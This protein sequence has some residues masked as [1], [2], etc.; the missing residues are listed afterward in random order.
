M[1]KI[2]KKRIRIFSSYWRCF[3]AWCCFRRKKKYQ[4]CNHLAELPKHLQKNRN[5]YL[6]PCSWR[7][8]FA[9]LSWFQHLSLY[10]IYFHWVHMSE[11]ATDNNVTQKLSPEH[12]FEL[13][14]LERWS[15]NRGSEPTFVQYIAWSCRYRSG[16]VYLF[17]IA[18]FF[19]IVH[20][21]TFLSLSHASNHNFFTA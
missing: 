20:M 2:E 15:V 4:E 7:S 1:Q 13:S 5:D 6:Y 11:F 14:K 21:V 9:P 12:K 3:L 19:H 18:S 17:H 16:F 10:A 8:I